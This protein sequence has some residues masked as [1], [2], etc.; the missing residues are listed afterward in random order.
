MAHALAALPVSLSSFIAA[1]I[2]LCCYSFRPC[3]PDLERRRTHPLVMRRPL[4]AFPFCSLYF[5]LTQMRNDRPVTVDFVRPAPDCFSA[6]PLLSLTS[7]SLLCSAA[8]FDDPD[9]LRGRCSQIR[10]SFFSSSYDS[11][12]RLLITLAFY[13]VSPLLI[14]DSSF[15]LK[16]FELPL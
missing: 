4:T 16:P 6:R 5:L 1:S 13:F 12:R 11:Y 7:L 10:E 15:S 14:R 9:S 3:Q 8:V 2:F